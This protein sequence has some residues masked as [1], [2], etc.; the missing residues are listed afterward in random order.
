MADLAINAAGT[1]DGEHV[2]LL[3]DKSIGL[4][5]DVARKYNGTID[6]FTGNGLIVLFGVPAAH[7]N[8]PELAI[9]AALDMLS[10]IQ[11]LNN[12]LEETYDFQLQLRI[13]ISTGEVIA[14]RMGS[15]LHMEY[16]VVGNSVNLATN[17]KETAAPGTILIGSETH[18]RTNKIFEFETV[19]P[20][21]NSTDPSTDQYY[22]LLK[23]ISRSD[24]VRG[25]TG[26]QLALVGRVEELTR[27]EQ[28][29]DIVY[30][31]KQ[32]RIV[33]LT[34]EAGIGKSK[35]IAEFKQKIGLSSAIRIHQ[36]ACPTYACSRPLSVVV[37]MVR[38]ILGL[39]ATDPAG[40]QNQSHSTLL[41]SN[42][43]V[44]ARNLALF[45]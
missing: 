37:E 33:Q 31:D 30:R 4:L 7:E 14:G 41:R 21:I 20:S 17:L 34:G 19:S 8:D 40:V 15:N 5:A 6:K 26:Q 45:G 27:L 25:L 3:I 18:Q 2:Y 29:L 35:L 39:T 42:E 32:R 1:L 43:P 44:G 16:T 12:Q 23:E 11:P 10:A 36:S 13:G 38:K 22:R 28:V 24:Q 9:R